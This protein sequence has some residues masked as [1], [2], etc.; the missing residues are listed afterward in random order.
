MGVDP[1][2][3]CGQAAMLRCFRATNREGSQAGPQGSKV[4]NYRVSS[5]SM[6]EVVIV[7]FVVDTL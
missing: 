2:W 4:P 5:V 3:S 1:L 7:V 6:L